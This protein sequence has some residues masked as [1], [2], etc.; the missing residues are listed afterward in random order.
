MKSQKACCIGSLKAEGGICG[1]S[2][3]QKN[4]H[5]LRGQRDSGLASVL[6]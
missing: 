1:R 2:N 5:N 6:R 4:A 3:E